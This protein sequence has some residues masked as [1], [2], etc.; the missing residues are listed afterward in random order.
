MLFSLL[1]ENIRSHCLRP[2]RNY[3]EQVRRI[4]AA[5]LPHVRLIFCATASL[6]EQMD[7]ENQYQ[8]DKCAKKCDAEKGA[9]LMTVPYVLSLQIKRFD[10]DWELDRRVK[11]DDQVTFPFVLDSKYT[12]NH[13]GRRLLVRSAWAYPTGR[14]LVTSI[15]QC[16]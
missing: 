16:L 10:Y 5:F 7:G 15:N 1:F 11:L 3:F 13:T 6:Q 2:V 14:V 8:C 4:S 9:A 12:H